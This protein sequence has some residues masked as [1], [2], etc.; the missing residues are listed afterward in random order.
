[1]LVRYVKE[2]TETCQMNLSTK[3][4]QSHAVLSVRHMFLIALIILF[5]YLNCPSWAKK[6]HTN[7]Y[8]RARIACGL[9]VHNSRK[10]RVHIS[11]GC[12][13]FNI[14]SIRN[15]RKINRVLHWWQLSHTNR[16]SWILSELTFLPR[17]WIGIRKSGEFLFHFKLHG[18]VFN[19]HIR[20]IVFP[21]TKKNTYITN[22]EITNRLTPVVIR[23]WFDCI[24]FEIKVDANEA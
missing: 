5:P 1:M 2:N 3:I 15:R 19:V 20:N 23:S 16:C 9:S 18:A 21:Q 12:R 13:I 4:C 22:L 24:H 11:F 14:Q 6:A 7:T 8:T 10:D 17:L